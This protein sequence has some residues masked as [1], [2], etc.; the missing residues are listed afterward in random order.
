MCQQSN[1]KERIDD[2]ED[3]VDYKE[4]D[5]V[6]ITQEFNKIQ[7]LQTVDASAEINDDKREGTFVN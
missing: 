6:I 5:I 3:T 2:T 4:D 1:T 7:H